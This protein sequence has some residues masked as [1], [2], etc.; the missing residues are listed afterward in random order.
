MP[1]LMV[2]ASE[3]LFIINNTFRNDQTGC[4]T[5]GSGS[6]KPAQSK[7]SYFSAST[8]YIDAKSLGFLI[9]KL[10]R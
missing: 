1:F 10:D 6:L 7:S 2:C 5:H 3:N 9:R 8:Q 4:E